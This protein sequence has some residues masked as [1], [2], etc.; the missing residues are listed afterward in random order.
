MPV[1]SDR[2][3]PPE[4]DGSKVP[5]SLA[6]DGQ[7]AH[8]RKRKTSA[9]RVRPEYPSGKPRLRH[10]CG[11]VGLRI[12]SRGSGCIMCSG[13]AATRRTLGIRRSRRQG[14][15][16][17]DCSSPTLDRGSNP[18]LDDG[19]ENHRWADLPR[20][21]QGLADCCEWF[22]SQS[23]LGRCKAGV[24]SLRSRQRRPH[25]LGRTCARLC[26][27]RGGVGADP[28]LARA[29]ERPRRQSAIWDASSGSAM[30]STIQSGSSRS[31][32]NRD[33]GR[34]MGS[35]PERASRTRYSN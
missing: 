15:S 20:D 9:R 32:F 16:C 27:D 25:V 34:L 17:S 35:I 21:Q 22:Q 7:L 3:S 4:F 24:P 8:R 1:C 30:P 10:D 33:A 26:H 2:T 23:P 29:R 14:Q 6:S 11:V 18:G 13:S 12:A 28:V 19:G 31:R 5:R